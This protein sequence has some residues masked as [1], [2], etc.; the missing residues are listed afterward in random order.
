MDAPVLNR[1]PDLIPRPE[2]HHLEARS[3][4]AQ[5]HREL[6]EREFLDVEQIEYFPF[7]RRQAF[8]SPL[9]LLHSSSAVELLFDMRSVVVPARIDRLQRKPDAL[10]APVIA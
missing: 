8:K 7:P 3:G 9:D 5:H 6:H 1:L 4:F 10:P 2:Q